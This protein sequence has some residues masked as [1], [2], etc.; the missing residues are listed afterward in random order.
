VTFTVSI[1][2]TGDPSMAYGEETVRGVARALLAGT[3][4]G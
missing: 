2:T 4:P 1:F 3:P